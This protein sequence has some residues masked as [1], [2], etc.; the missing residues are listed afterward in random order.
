MDGYK[1][2]NQPGC[3]LIKWVTCLVQQ[4]ERMMSW[5]L[6]TY[7]SAGCTKDSGVGTVQK[8]CVGGGGGGGG[9]LKLII[10]KWVW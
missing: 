5:G 7:T 6:F 4:L 10:D 9:G 3:W 8:V 2:T 1:Q